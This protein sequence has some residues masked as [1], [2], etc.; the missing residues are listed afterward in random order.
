LG[1]VSLLIFKNLLFEYKFNPYSR[2]YFLSF[3]DI[4]GTLKKVVD[5]IDI[6]F[7]NLRNRFINRLFTISIIIYWGFLPVAPSDGKAT[8]IC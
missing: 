4:I 1:N 6:N 5:D 2:G 8:P 7:N 3:V